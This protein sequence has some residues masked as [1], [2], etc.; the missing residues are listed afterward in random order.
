MNPK[1]IQHFRVWFIFVRPIE[2]SF[3]VFNFNDANSK[4]LIGECT[5]NLTELMMAPDQSLRCSLQ[6]EANSTTKSG[7]KIKNLKNRGF[8]IVRADKVKKTEDIIKFQISAHLKSQ[9]FLCLGID[10]PYLQIERARQNNLNSLVR[11]FKTSTAHG[12][13][14]PWWEPHQ[15]YMTDFCNNNKQLPLR[16]SVYN[17]KNSGAHNLYGSVDTT[18][19]NIEMLAGGTLALKD[20][21]GKVKGTITFNQ[22]MMDMR[23]SL[24]EYLKHGWQMNVSIAID[25]TLSNLE[26]KDQRSLHRQMRNGEMNQY[27]KAI[28]EV[29][30]VMCKYAIEGSFNVYGFGGIPHYMGYKNKV[31][32]LWNLNGEDDPRCKGTMEV[33]KAYQKGIMGTTLAGPSYF[34]KLL[35]H[36]QEEIT[37]SLYERGLDAN[38]IYHV[39]IIITDGN[40]HDMEETKRLLV[41]L[42]GMPFS[43]VVIGVGDG[44][45]EK[46]EI[47]D[48]DGEILTDENG[49]EA[50]RDIVQLVQYGDFKDLGQRELAL[51]VLGELPDQ[52]VDYMVMLENERHKIWKPQEPEPSEDGRTPKDTGKGQKDESKLS[53]E[54]REDRIGDEIKSAAMT[55]KK[56]LLGG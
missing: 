51:E 47:L 10:Q 37:G 39:V 25:F 28:F 30:N 41:S 56:I 24:I 8:L 1:W 20:A 38:R 52:F 19:R 33:L 55:E 16:I 50:I 43:A 2:L 48:A 32:R 21:K 40:C 29:C 53:D 5:F 11:V 42:S 12:D 49:N 22:F 18:T 45:F 23:P 26:I 4:D 9:K 27:E 34:G 13:I 35:S 3:Q 14:N 17:Y 54:I 15:L 46:M 7:K 36:V 6:L 44:D 31:S